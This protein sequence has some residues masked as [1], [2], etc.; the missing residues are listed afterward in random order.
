MI[1][2]YSGGMDST[3]AL[4]EYRDLISIAV[5][6]IYP[7]IHNTREI[8]F[9]KLNT[10]RLGVPHLVMNAT[11]M[12][13]G[14]RSGLF[15]GDIPDGHYTDASMART[16][17]PFRNGIFVSVAAGLA[18]SMGL[19]TVIL[20]NHSGDHAIYADCRGEFVAKLNEAIKAGTDNHVSLWTP[21]V[22][23]SKREIALKGR[24]MKVDFMNTWSCYNG[25][26]IHCGTCGT[27]VERKEALEGFDTTKYKQ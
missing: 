25:A 8:H 19:S 16:V 2:I 15:S 21:Y 7:A 26:R 5:S 20:A 24:D 13:T 4:H 3:V 1:L 23:I 18:E 17:V 14:F 27:C 9:A 11:D 12:F 22:N 6:F 10:Q